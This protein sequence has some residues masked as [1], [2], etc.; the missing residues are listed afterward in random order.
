MCDVLRDVCHGLTSPWPDWPSRKSDFPSFYH[1]WM[2]EANNF[3]QIGCNSGR[4]YFIPNFHKSS[5]QNCM[6]LRKVAHWP[7]YPT[8]PMGLIALR[9]PSLEAKGSPIKTSL[10]FIMLLF[11]SRLTY[12]CGKCMSMTVPKC[13]HLIP[14]L[15]FPIFCACFPNNIPHLNLLVLYSFTKSN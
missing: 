15:I 1:K 13:V 12:K 5:G 6:G 9:P 14:S 4:R 3:V 11:F 8:Q 7:T 10:R 2:E